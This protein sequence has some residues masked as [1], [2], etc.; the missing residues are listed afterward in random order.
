M[1][2]AVLRASD[3]AAAAAVEGAL[4]GQTRPPEKA[5]ALAP[6]DDPRRALPAGTEWAWLLDG[7]AV[8]EAPALERLL[9]VAEDPGPLPAPILL[10]SRILTEDGSFDPTSLPVAQVMDRD[11]ALAAFERRV[12]SLRLVRAG[13][14]LVHRDWLEVPDHPGLD[15]FADDLEWSARTL[16]RGPGMLVPG[17]VAV[18]G[19]LDPRGT[20]RRERRALVERA[21]LLR[22]DAIDPTD[23]PWFVLRVLEDAI[24]HVRSLSAAR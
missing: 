13:S 14:L 24:A 12:V 16:W 1:V 15:P 8:P 7:S 5:V 4:E 11:V 3:P 10:A 18:R 2:C 6:G 22:T 19:P 20:R 21:R 23:K 17:S 9:E